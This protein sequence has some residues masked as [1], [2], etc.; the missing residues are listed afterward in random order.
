MFI[1]F[2]VKQYKHFPYLQECQ[3]YCRELPIS[4]IDQLGQT[5]HELVNS[6][7]RK[8]A[9]AFAEARSKYICTI[10]DSSSKILDWLASINHLVV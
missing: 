5:I 2:P 8:I 1:D 7:P 6:D 10:N 9:E 4:Q 3:P